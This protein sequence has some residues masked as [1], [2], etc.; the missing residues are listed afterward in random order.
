[1]DKRDWCRNDQ[2]TPSPSISGNISPRRTSR[3]WCSASAPSIVGGSRGAYPGHGEAPRSALKGL[4]RRGSLRQLPD[5][6]PREVRSFGLEGTTRHFANSFAGLYAISEAASS[7]IEKMDM[8]RASRDRS[9]GNP[10]IESGQPQPVL[11]CKSEKIEI[12]DPRR[13]EQFRFSQVLGIK[14]REVIR[15]EFVALILAKST[16]HTADFSS[17]PEGIRVRTLA[18]HTD[19]PILHQW[20]GQPAQA[21]RSLHPAVRGLM[22]YMLRIQQREQRVQIEQEAIHSDSSRS[23]LTI[24]GVTV[25][26]PA[27]T[28]KRRSPLRTEMDVRSL[29]RPRRASSEMTVP[30]GS[31]LCR[32]NA[33]AEARISSSKVRVVLTHPAS[34]ITHRGSRWAN[35]KRR[36]PR[37]RESERPGRCPAAAGLLMTLRRWPQSRRRLKQQKQGSKGSKEPAIEGAAGRG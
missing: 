6:A 37:N 17:G 21:G 32:A 26:A 4:F 23:R 9:N 31:S 5:G 35:R 14:E 18:R 11:S 10:A 24:S 33:R 12:G 1:M 8:L 29:E 22:K 2:A 30:R 20:T 7:C 13:R 36:D 3:V 27:R 19:D 34:R 16:Q 15:T 25:P 28:G